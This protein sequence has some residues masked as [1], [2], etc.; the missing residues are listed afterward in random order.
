MNTPYIDYFVSTIA[1]DNVIITQ[2]IC[3]SFF[4]NSFD[5][6]IASQ[7]LLCLLDNKDIRNVDFSFMRVDIF[8]R[9]IITLL[10]C[11]YKVPM[12]SNGPHGIDVFIM[13]T[14]TI[15][16][17]QLFSKQISFRQDII[18]K[19]ILP[20]KTQHIMLGISYVSFYQKPLGTNAL[21][22]INSWG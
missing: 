22:N 6:T 20:V 7:H 12:P 5:I 1:T 19:T 18:Y 17:V 9:C 3:F 21:W 11:L 10:I 2:N 14:F 8:Y 4:Q 13:S 16:S 15:D